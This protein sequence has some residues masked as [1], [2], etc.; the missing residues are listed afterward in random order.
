[1]PSAT[2]QKLIER[3]EA[4]T[5]HLKV[6]LGGIRTGRASLTL[7][8]GIKVDYYGTQTPLKQVATLGV[9]ES[10]LLTVQPWEPPL[11]KE[12][13]KALLASGLGLTPSNDGKLIRI[14]I[15]PLSEERRRELIKLC[16]KHG[17]EAKVHLRNIR[18]EGNEEFKRLQ[19]E[20]K[21]TEDDLRKAEAEVQKLTDQY[22][23]KVDQILKKKEEEILEV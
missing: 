13:E 1:M 5:E 12:I 22:V 9:P 14:P 18:R 2:K 6:E 21:I 8:D 11:I 3:M 19:K 20:S 4:A 7:L 17:E 23:Q 15:P 10:R 16:K